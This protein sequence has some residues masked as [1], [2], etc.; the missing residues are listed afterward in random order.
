MEDGDN[1]N[2]ILA[3]NKVNGVRKPAHQ[4]TPKIFEDAGICERIIGRTSDG[5]IQLKQKLNA[6]P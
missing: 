1:S 4:N 5:D 6:E 3:S 2:H